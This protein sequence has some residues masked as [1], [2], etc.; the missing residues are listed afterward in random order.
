VDQAVSDLESRYPDEAPRPFRRL[1]TKL[2][3][4][5][6]LSLAALDVQ[7]RDQALAALL[8]DY[9]RELDGATALEARTRKVAADVYQDDP[10]GALYE[11]VQALEAA[12]G[13]RQALE[14]I[15]ARLHAG[16]AEILGTPKSRSAVRTPAV[17]APTE[18]TAAGG[19]LLRLRSDV[20]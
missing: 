11:R 15:G 5:V 10:D 18:Q 19:T 14:R 9:A 16:L 4:A 12:L 3:D 6:E 13:K 7:D 20:G 17:P 1:R 8:L 2:A